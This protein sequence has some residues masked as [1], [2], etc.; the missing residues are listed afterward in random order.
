MGESLLAEARTSEVSQVA[1]EGGR[2]GSGWAYR[3]WDAEVA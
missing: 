2:E 3:V 1:R